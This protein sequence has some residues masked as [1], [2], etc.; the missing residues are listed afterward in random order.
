MCQWRTALELDSQRR[1]TA[2][3]DRALADSIRCGADLRVGTEFVHNQHIDVTSS[4]A[5][6]IREVAEFR[7]TYLIEDCWVAGVMSLRQPINLP[8]GF[9]P[10][11]SMSF[12]LYNQDGQQ[13]IARP[14]LDGV[15]AEGAP[16]PSPLDVPPN[17]PR[18][19]TQSSFDGATNAPSSN[20]IYDFECFRFFV[21][22]AWREVYAHDAHGAPL[23]GSMDALIDAFSRGCQLKIGVRNLC[24]GLAEDPA[25]A[26]NHEIF[27][28][29]GPGYYYTAEKLFMVGSHPVI[30]VRPARPM[31]YTTRG[32]D[33]GWLMPRTDGRVV[34]RRCDPYT[35]AFNDMESRCAMRWFVR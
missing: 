32:W 31:L 22:D 21:C 30:R 8:L 24:S 4:R 7:V 29:V 6:L 1:V 10:R 15:P 13:A 20:F 28:E 14:Y 16:G 17:M 19:H 25:S 23:S 5:E 2:G 11:P 35:L 26:P 34:Y 3:S 27:V 33:F 18:Y 9:G 12:F